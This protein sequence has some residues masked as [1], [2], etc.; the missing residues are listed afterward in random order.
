[1]LAR[2][3]AALSEKYPELA[4]QILGDYEG[5]L[6]N[7]SDRIVL[8]DT[9]GNPADEVQYYEG[10]QWPKAADGRGS[11]L[12]LR[13]PFADNAYGLAWAASDESQTS[14][15]QTYRYQGIAAASAVGPD[16][17]W[18]ELVMGM[19]TDG[20]VLLDDIQVIQ[21][22][23]GAAINLIQNSTF[24][25]DAVGSSAAHWRLIGN[26]RHSEVVVDPDDP[27]NQVLRFVATGATEHMHNHAE[28]TLMDDG[29]I[30]TITN[31]V[32]YEISYRAKWITGSNLLNTRLYFD[33]LA[34]TTPIKQPVAHGT[35]GRQNS[36]YIVNQGPVY[37]NLHHQPVVPDEGQP[38]TVNV[39]IVDMQA[40]AAA[41]LWYSIE[42]GDWQSVPM[43]PTQGTTFAGQIP[44]QSSATI[45]Q[46]YVEATDALGASTT[47]PRRS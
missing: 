42:G 13:D 27:N 26:H 15:W 12:E 11:S 5:N 25:E 39:D 3:G 38:V 29:Q 22:P 35:P 7:F 1:M 44:G 9:V 14:T 6:S 40:V 20:E 2:D 21:D 43:A 4:G 19:L 36:S 17:Q 28:T 18:Q 37:D 34:R 31:G 41:E 10:G 24:E 47:F 16:G 33:R 23:G 8:R 45:V 32:E 46:F 30:A